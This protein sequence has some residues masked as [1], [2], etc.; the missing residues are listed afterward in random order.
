MKCNDYQELISAGLD[1]QL[2]PEETR[3]LKAHLETCA[4]CREFAETAGDLCRL[5]STEKGELLPTGLEREILRKTLRT[6]RG[7]LARLF[8]N[9][10]QI[11]G[12]IVWAAAAALLF[13]TVHTLMGPDE[14]PPAAPPQ[15]AGNPS[16]AQ[17]TEVRTI[18]VTTADM[19]YRQ[20]HDGGVSNQ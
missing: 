5:S 11:P 9:N 6:E 13:L 4:E 2:S 12:P 1:D 14:Q 17:E 20:S 15:V 8:R 16:L 18:H 7:F 19:V 10:Y 3:T